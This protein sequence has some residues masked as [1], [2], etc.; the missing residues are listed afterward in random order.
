MTGIK[1]SPDDTESIMTVG[2]ERHTMNPHKEKS[3]WPQF[4]LLVALFVLC[5]FA[6]SAWQTARK[7]V[8]N[9]PSSQ[10]E[11]SATRNT[12]SSTGSLSAAGS[13][14]TPSSAVNT[15]PLVLTTSIEP[16]P[17]VPTNVGPVAT[18]LSVTRLVKNQ[19]LASSST[20]RQ[21]VAEPQPVVRFATVLSPV[22]A[23]QKET[24]SWDANRVVERQDGPLVTQPKKEHPV[25]LRMI[26]YRVQTATGIWPQPVSL[27]EELAGIAI[28]PPAKSW[29]QKVQQ[30]LGQL[31][32]YQSLT[33]PS[34]RQTLQQLSALV[35]SGNKKAEATKDLDFQS[36]WLRTIYSLE[37]R[38]TIWN[39]IYQHATAAPE[40]TDAAAEDTTMLVNQLLTIGKELESLSNGKSWKDYLLIDQL[41]AATDPVNSSTLSQLACRTLNRI[42]SPILT[43]EQ[44]RFLTT[45]SLPTIQAPL[46]NLIMANLEPAQLLAQLERYESETTSQQANRLAA[47]YQ[48]LKWSLN[49]RERQ[50]ATQLDTHYRNANIR[51]AMSQQ[52]INRLLPN[53]QAR[54]ESIDDIILGARVSGKSLTSTMLKVFLIP[55]KKQWRMGVQASGEVS[56]DTETRRRA[57]TFHNKGSSRYTVNKDLLVDRRG[58]RVSRAVAET[59]IQS[60]LL[61]FETAFDSLPL[62][63]AMMRSFIRNQYNSQAGQARTIYENRVSRRARNQFD[64]EI[65]NQLANLEDRFQSRYLSPLKQLN[66]SPMVV[67]LQTTTSSRL[68][69]RYRL[70]GNEQLAAHTP[71]PRAPGD[72]LLSIQIH[73]SAINNTLQNLKLDGKRTDLRSLYQDIADAFDRP[74]I[75]IPEDIPANVTVAMADHEAVRV[76]FENGKVNLRIHLK[77]LKSGTRHK[78]RNFILTVS[79]RPAM[80]QLTA[81]LYRDGHLQF[82]GKHLRLGDRIALQ[83]IFN[84]A[85]PRTRPVNIFNKNISEHTR[86]QDLTV[87]QFV[88]RN[89]WIGVA[90]GP[91]ET[92]EPRVAKRPKNRTE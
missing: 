11:N 70:A 49:D 38:L 90:I 4:L 16:L 44:R 84:K 25:A 19:S 75:T 18:S 35:K 59:D 54:E 79:Y 56:S 32:A 64:E 45:G 76:R 83:G 6:P 55:D 24:S 8:P 89:T 39:A 66:L 36:S 60:E 53:P 81:S 14:Q 48:L 68:I 34:T 20:R 26:S 92:A 42:E 69:L 65:T 12:D 51:I 91:L 73:E 61:G 50:L 88:I 46:R 74:D 41:L 7:A 23:D 37:R 82:E 80:D 3:L 21:R 9:S 43:A 31:Q 28:Y 62:V 2:R 5:L 40:P 71:R 72:S 33:D 10:P 27:L 86:L 22:T 78:W 52:M 15:S 1:G 85:L 17:L 87:T 30:Q 47:Q 63:G 13:W 57:A 29:A 77:E 67:D 58:I